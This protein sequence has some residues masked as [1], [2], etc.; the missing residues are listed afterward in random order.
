[1]RIF[2]TDKDNTN[3]WNIKV[4]KWGQDRK[5]KTD[6]KDSEFNAIEFVDKLKFKEHGWNKD[7]V[8]YERPYTKCGLIAQELQALDESLVVDYETYLGLDALR[9]INIALKAVQEL[10]QQNKELKQKLEE[11]TNG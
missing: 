4:E 10:S 7:E 1:M 5:L 3:K 8:G 9:L 2:G 6:I 11:I